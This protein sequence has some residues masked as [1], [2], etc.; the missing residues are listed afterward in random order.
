MYWCYCELQ[1]YVTIWRYFTIQIIHNVSMPAPIMEGYAW[2]KTTKLKQ[3][4]YQN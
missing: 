1:K 3:S 2:V 4:Y